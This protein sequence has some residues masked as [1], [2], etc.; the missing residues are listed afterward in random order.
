VSFF[1]RSSVDAADLKTQNRRT[2]KFDDNSFRLDDFFFRSEHFSDSEK[3]HEM[4][5]ATETPPK[6]CFLLSDDDEFPPMIA[7][8]P[9]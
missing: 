6:P 4:S 3:F 8:L 5:S 2:R 9:S 1:N 7:N